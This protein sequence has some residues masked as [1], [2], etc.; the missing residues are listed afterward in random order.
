[1]EDYLT[2]LSKKR[3]WSV[4]YEMESSDGM[5]YEHKSLSGFEDEMKM[6]YDLTCD[7]YSNH[8][9]KAFPKEFYFS[10]SKYMKDRAQISVALKN[11]ET[12]GMFLYLISNGYAGAFHSGIPAKDFTYFNLAYYDLISFA[13]RINVKVINYRSGSAEAKMARGCIAVPRYISVLPVSF[14]AKVFTKAVKS[15][16]KALCH[17][18]SIIKSGGR[19]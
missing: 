13:Y 2:S 3:R 19:K 15:G 17:A 5:I 9:L 4:K 16:Q 6:L 7:K 14:K 18:R 12:K 11:G 8:D 10:I 1:M